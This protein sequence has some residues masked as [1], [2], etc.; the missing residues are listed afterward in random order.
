[1]TLRLNV[2][3]CLPDLP[4]IRCPQHFFVFKSIHQQ[5]SRF[6]KRKRKIEFNIHKTSLISLHIGK[7]NTWEDIWDRNKH[8]YILEKYFDWCGVS[9]YTPPPTVGVEVPTET[10]ESHLTNSVIS[11]SLIFMHCTWFIVS[12]Y[13]TNFHKLELQP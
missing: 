10:I 6:G 7:P 5:A 3:L 2:Q 9:F 13:S 4:V 12:I 11:A 8:V 1:M